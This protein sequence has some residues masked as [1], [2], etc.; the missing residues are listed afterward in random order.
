[1]LKNRTF[2]ERRRITSLRSER[3]VMSHNVDYSRK[4]AEKEKATWTETESSHLNLY[5]TDSAVCFS[6][7]VNEAVRVRL[8][9]VQE[10]PNY[11]Q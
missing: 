4:S 9:N 10:G 5:F 2:R 1:M 8:L 7:W 11:I 6:S 3:H